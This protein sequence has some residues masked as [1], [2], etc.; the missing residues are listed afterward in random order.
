MDAPTP[1]EALPHRSH[2]KLWWACALAI[3]F[4]GVALEYP[5]YDATFTPARVF[6]WGTD[7][8]VHVYRAKIIARNQ[9]Q[10]TQL[11]ASEAAATRPKASNST[12]PRRWTTSWPA[13]A[14]S[15]R[16]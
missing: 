11:E 4:G 2:R 10:E 7:D 16:R 12:G 14:H 8:Y 15:P 1:S 13:P 9:A 3:A 5:R 6:F